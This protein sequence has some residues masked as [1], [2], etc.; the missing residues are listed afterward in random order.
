MIGE[1][2]R[3]VPR[4]CVDSRSCVGSLRRGGRFLRGP[5]R[6]RLFEPRRLDGMGDR[7]GTGCGAG[8]RRLRR[9]QLPVRARSRCLPGPVPDVASR[10]RRA[11][12]RGWRKLR[13]RVELV[14]RLQ[15]HV[16]VHARRVA[17]GRCGHVCHVHRGRRG[18]PVDVGGRPRGTI[19]RIVH[20]LSRIRVPVRGRYLRLRGLRHRSDP[21]P[22]HPGDVELHARDAGVP[23]AASGPRVRLLRRWRHRVPLRR[24][25]LLHGRSPASVR[26]RRVDRF[27]GAGMP[28]NAVRFQPAT[29]DDASTR[30]RQ[31]MSVSRSTI[32][33]PWRVPAGV[34]GRQTVST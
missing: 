22:S 2:A 30:H 25:H 11:L 18:V 4:G 3:L 7:H 23:V 19:G 6:G 32:F 31:R 10:H 15:S 21:S 9:G 28:V 24:R 8:C 27:L 26:R 14:A 13:V 1:H 33:R 17:G 12:P 16:R 29:H 5:A 20:G 34:A